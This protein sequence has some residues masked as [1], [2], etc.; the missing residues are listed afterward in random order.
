MSLETFN[1]DLSSWDV[2]SG[3]YFGSMFYDTADYA[4]VFNLNLTGWN[5]SSAVNMYNMFYAAGYSAETFSLGNLSSWDT[6]NVTNMQ[7]M[8]YYAGYNATT[9]NSF[10]SL[11]VYATN[12]QE[13]FRGVPLANGT[14]NIYTR[15]TSYSYMF[16]NAAT[17]GSGIVVNYTSSVTNIDN[18]VATKSSNSNV[19]KGSIIS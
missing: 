12:V 6:R 10:G 17:S 8:F 16:N 7:G 1:L 15:P 19:T 11:K 9:W 5:P 18:L 2:S 14:L 3:Q 13:M 4:T